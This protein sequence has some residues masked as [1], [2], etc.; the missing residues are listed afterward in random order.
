VCEPHSRSRRSGDEK[1]ELLFFGHFSSK[2][3]TLIELGRIETPE[4]G[5][6]WPKHIV[7]VL[8]GEYFNDCCIIDGL[9][10]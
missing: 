2:L 8:I 6:L 4:D 9:D 1:I 10:T 3:V 5:R 7:L